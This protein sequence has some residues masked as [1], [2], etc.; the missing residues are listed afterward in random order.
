MKT[1][2]ALLLMLLLIPLEAAAD[3]GKF[4]DQAAR[5]ERGSDARVARGEAKAE[6]QKAAKDKRAKPVESPPA[7]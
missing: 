2:G 7:K 5:R 4:N 1:S 3:M 6:R